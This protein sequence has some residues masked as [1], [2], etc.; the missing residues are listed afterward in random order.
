VQT[1]TDWSAYLAILPQ[2]V[3]IAISGPAAGLPPEQVEGQLVTPSPTLVA[4]TLCQRLPP[5][6]PAQSVVAPQPVYDMDNGG[7]QAAPSLH[8]TC[9]RPLPPFAHDNNPTLWFPTPPHV[10]LPPAP[11]PV[12]P[13]F[14]LISPPP[15]GLVPGS[16]TGRATRCPGVLPLDGLLLLPPLLGVQPPVM[17]LVSMM[18]ASI[19]TGVQWHLSTCASFSAIHYQALVEKR[20]PCLDGQYQ[21]NTHQRWETLLFPL[22]VSI[23]W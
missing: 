2:P 3:P 8:P 23:W 17:P 1:T 16:A 5:R 13:S 14:V 22:F 6:F 15:A 20:S 9:R 21:C 12:A 7:V 18:E 11:P 10:A 4:L 19:V